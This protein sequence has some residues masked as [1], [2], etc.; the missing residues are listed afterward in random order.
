MAAMAATTLVT[1]A[2]G[3]AQFQAPF[4]AG[5]RCVGVRMSSNNGGSFSNPLPAP[6]GKRVDE[7]VEFPTLMRF[8]IVGVDEPTFLSDMERI[9]GEVTRRPVTATSSRTRGRFRSVTVDL[10]LDT[11]EDFYRAYTKVSE[12][13]RVKFML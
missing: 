13:A 4:R 2:F 11:P 8:K 5:P 6:S 1:L 7:T 3:G 12:D 9:C 10:V